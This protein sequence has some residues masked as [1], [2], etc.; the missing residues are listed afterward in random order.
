MW[1]R[2]HEE[3]EPIVE[4]DGGLRYPLLKAFR[5]NGKKIRLTGW[6]KVETDRTVVYCDAHDRSRR[7]SLIY[8]IP[9]GRWILEG[10]AHSGMLART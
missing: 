10:F 7:F 8:D 1:K 9:T 3:I 5:W 2:V 4:Y 6:G